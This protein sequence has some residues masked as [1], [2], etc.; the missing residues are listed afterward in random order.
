MASQC[1]LIQEL[2][3]IKENKECNENPGN[4]QMKT[5]IIE[6]INITIIKCIL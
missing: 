5:K 2:T 4:K 3:H 6:K 1:S